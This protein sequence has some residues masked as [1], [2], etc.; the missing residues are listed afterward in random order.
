MQSLRYLKKQR[1]RSCLSI[2]IHMTQSQTI[3]VSITSSVD[4][5]TFSGLNKHETVKKQLFTDIILV[6]MTFEDSI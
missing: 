1:V 4:M 5:K 2:S 3:F 6:R